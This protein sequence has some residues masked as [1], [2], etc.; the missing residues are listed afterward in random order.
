MFPP[1]PPT[2]LSKQPSFLSSTIFV[3]NLVIS[4]HVADTVNGYG[5]LS[6]L[7]QKLVLSLLLAMT[8]SLSNA[9]YFV[10]HVFLHTI[11]MSNFDLLGECGDVETNPGPTGKMLIGTYNTSGCKNYSKLKCIMTWLFKLRKTD[12]FVFSLQ[13]THLSTKDLA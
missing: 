4:C 2:N 3:S 5:R 11:G 13:E 8:Q 1:T 9:Y 12:R 10:F 7:N 6:C